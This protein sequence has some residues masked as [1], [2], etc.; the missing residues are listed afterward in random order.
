MKEKC[1][2]CSGVG[3]ST[4]IEKVKFGKE[5]YD[6]PIIVDCDYCMGTGE[7]LWIEN[8]CKRAHYMRVVDGY[9]FYNKTGKEIQL[10]NIMIPLVIGSNW[11]PER[12]LKEYL[13]CFDL[14]K[15]I[16]NQMVDVY[17]KVK[18]WR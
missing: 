2:E 8:I 13:N 6:I 5:E 1:F 4:R 15:L 7:V 11:I 12:C 18:E 14:V 3:Y 10:T 9:I 17:I 16:D